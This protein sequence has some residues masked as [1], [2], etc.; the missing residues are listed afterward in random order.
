MESPGAKRIAFLLG[1]AGSGKTSRCLQEIRTALAASPEGPPLLYL[2]PKQATYQLERQLLEPGTPAGYTRLHILSFERLATL[3]LDEL[4]LPQLG[5]FISEEGRVMVLRTLL[6]RCEHRLDTFRTSARLGGFAQQ[7][8]QV[9]AELQQ[10]KIPPAQMRRLA[11]S[12]QLPA[13]LRAKLRDFALLA[14]EYGEWLKDHPVLDASLLVEQAVTA[15]KTASR[16][17]PVFPVAGLW[18]D[19]F[20]ELTPQ[21]I[22]LLLTILPGCEHATLA[23][24]LDQLPR[25]DL[26]WLST[27]S[28]LAQT[29]RR[30]H[31][32][33]SALAPDRVYVEVL[34]RGG[35]ARFATAPALRH[36]EAYWAQPLSAVTPSPAPGPE[37][38]LAACTTV[39][40]EVR[41]AAREVIKFVQA[42]GRYRETAILVRDL[43]PYHNPLRQIL[44]HYGVPFFLDRRESIAH[45]PLVELTRYSFRLAAHRWRHDDWFGAL[46]TGLCPLNDL[47]VDQLENR[48]LRYGWEGDTWLHPLPAEGKPDVPAWMVRTAELIARPFRQFIE[49]WRAEAGSAAV[50]PTGNQTARCV[51]RLWQSLRVEARL[52]HWSQPGDAPGAAELVHTSVWTRLQEWQANIEM[53][54]GETALPVEDW[55]PVLEAGLAGLTVGVIPPSLDQVLLGSIDRSRN[56]DL[57]LA[58]ILGLNEGVFPAPPP[59]PL[60]ITATERLELEKEQVFLDRNPR[61]WI[62][63][64]RYLGYI[65]FTRSRE[66]VIG[67]FARTGSKGQELNSSP[68]VAHLQKLLPGLAVEV[69]APPQT[70]ADV[71]HPCE[72]GPL[73]ARPGATELRRQFLAREDFAPLAHWRESVHFQPA[74]RLDPGLAQQ[75]FTDT[76]HTSVSHLEQFAACP[77]KFFVQ[78]AL[79]AQERLHFEIDSRHL[80][81]LH[82]NTLEAFH[83]AVRSQG[84]QWRDLTPGEAD[85]LLTEINRDLAAQYEHGLFATGPENRF[86]A[87]SALRMVQEYLRVVIGWMPDY[88]LDSEAVELAFGTRTP[89]LPPWLIPLADGR[90]V[91][92]NGRVDR[93]DLRR[94]PETNQAWFVVIDYKSSAKK[95]DPVQMAHGLQLQL[96]A[97]LSMLSLMPEASQHFG[98]GRLKPAGVFYANLRGAPPACGNREEAR[99]SAPTH[100]Q[101]TFQHSGRF[102]LQAL[103]LLD[104]R[105]DP[106]APGQFVF[107]LKKDGTPYSNCQEAMTTGDFARMVADVPVRLQQLAGRIL[108]GET[109]LA[110]FQH[111]HKTACEQC[112]YQAICRVDRWTQEF[113]QLSAPAP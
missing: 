33:V 52:R 107:R 30:C 55:L 84:R 29:F 5:A 108:S 85:L 21:E 8:S 102:D 103:P 44:T 60:L 46:K 65:A 18:L 111:Q 11:E 7:A 25:T 83:R 37:L 93:I 88:G 41:F 38:R 69:I 76:L 91:E 99:V 71:V 61:R 82:H 24:C 47:L 2:A 36:L 48:A 58:L 23:F 9:L 106:S 86:L 109:A 87:L 39:E 17:H 67:T 79:R 66:R 96:P 64:E 3:L 12:P 35:H 75:L 15:M 28:G 14:E 98:V 113:R 70:W 92:L 57:R 49:A 13:P 74:D 50:G 81:N 32:A 105:G 51:A 26:S 1:P 31:Q 90:A 34:A 22:D 16:E 73:L 62:G 104:G 54:F 45:H 10:Q 68:F 100:W 59:T 53:A 112:D 110:P 94:D 101:S 19:G 95:L 4:P 6:A 43:K 40:E 77:F 63:A 56:P 42:G 78:V 80:G 20:S 89:Q 72:L 97:Y 27:W